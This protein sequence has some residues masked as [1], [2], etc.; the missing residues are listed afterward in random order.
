MNTAELI[1]WISEHALYLLAIPLLP[2]LAYTLQIFFG[3]HLPRRGDWLPTT[4]M[5]AA[6]CI[7]VTFFVKT[8]G[9]FDQTFLYDSTRHGQCGTGGGPPG[10]RRTSW[11]S[12]SSTTTSPPS[13]SPW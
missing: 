12:E 3:N 6:F 10:A 11:E 7:A 8:M 9:V 13:C 2:L 5:F 1:T 4:A